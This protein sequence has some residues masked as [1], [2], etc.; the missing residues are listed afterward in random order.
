MKPVVAWLV[1]HLYLAV[2]VTLALVT[3]LVLVR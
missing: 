1:T 3:Y 2:W